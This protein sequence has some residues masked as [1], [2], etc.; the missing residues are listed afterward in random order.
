M[1]H[2]IFTNA[3][4]KYAFKGKQITNRIFGIHICKTTKTTLDNNLDIIN[5]SKKWMSKKSGKQEVPGR[6]DKLQEYLIMSYTQSHLNL[7]DLKYD[8]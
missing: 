5:C 6:R 8:H 7:Q 4:Y 3:I 1:I 2:I